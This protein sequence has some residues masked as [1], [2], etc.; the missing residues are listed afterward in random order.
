ME[1]KNNPPKKVIILLGPPGSG[2][3]TQA[4]RIMQESGIPHISTGDLF[5]D[6]ISKNTEL[7][8]QANSYMIKGNLVPDEVVLDM[9]FDRVSHADCQS[10]YLLDGFPRTIPQAEA[11]DK[12]LQNGTQVV[13]INLTVSDDVVMK[14]I[15]GR[16][17]C[18]QCGHVHNE[19][20][21]APKVEGKCDKCGIS[22][23]KRDDD[24]PEVVIERLNVYNK[25]TAPLIEYYE[26]KGILK[27]IDGEQDSEEIFKQIK[28]YL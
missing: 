23:V 19:Y 7:G 20:F 16:L 18:S 22:L 3:G 6:N 11:L 27:T 17:S 15:S 13:A 8:Q 24:Q 25:Q 28:P 9:L 14:R 12:Y 10:G 21:S 5:R 2:K 26:K 4:K 1:P